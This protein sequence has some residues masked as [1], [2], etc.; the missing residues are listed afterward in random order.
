M[1]SRQQAA[2]AAASL[3]RI[4][5]IVDRDATQRSDPYLR[6]IARTLER[7]S[8][9]VARASIDRRQLA[10]E[11]DRL[12]AHSQLAYGQSAQPA[13]QTAPGSAECA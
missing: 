9:E 11:L 4:A 5:E 12:I 2:D 1:L 13:G 6:T 10:S 7:L 3:R 8:A